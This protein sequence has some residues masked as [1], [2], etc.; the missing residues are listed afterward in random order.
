MTGYWV[1]TST[2]GDIEINWEYKE[3]KAEKET[4]VYLFDQ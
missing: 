2:Y 4:T 1:Q 3:A